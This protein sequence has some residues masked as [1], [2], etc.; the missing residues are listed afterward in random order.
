MHREMHVGCGEQSEP[1]LCFRAKFDAV[2]FIHHILQIF[3]AA[4]RGIEVCEGICKSAS[5]FS[6]SFSVRAIANIAAAS[7]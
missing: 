2:H 3:H 5:S 6:Q 7:M 1:H 4:K